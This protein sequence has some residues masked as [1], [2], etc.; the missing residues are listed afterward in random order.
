MPVR[1]SSKGQ[2]II[3]REIRQ[4]LGLKP[5]DLFEVRLENDEIILTLVLDSTPLDR[6]YGKFGQSNL[7]TALQNDHLEE[8][9][10][11]SP[12]TV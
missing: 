6:L 7:L 10:I 11:R 3:P 2:L 9:T 8:L 1:L 4:S 5:G 12:D